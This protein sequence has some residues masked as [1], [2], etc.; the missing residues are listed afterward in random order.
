VCNNIPDC[1]KIDMA[2]S[3]RLRCKRLR[4]I[5][6]SNHFTGNILKWTNRYK[7]NADVCLQFEHTEDSENEE[8]RLHCSKLYRLFKD[9]FK[10]NNPNTKVP[11]NKIFIG[12]KS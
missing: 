11:N 9:W 1:D 12:I 7:K 4:C 3:K 8:D 2:F 6:F 10:N 5:S